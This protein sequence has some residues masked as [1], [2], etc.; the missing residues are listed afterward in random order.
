MC[1]GSPNNFQS[2]SDCDVHADSACGVDWSASGVEY[3]DSGELLLV[4][5][6]LSELTK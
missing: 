2:E 1:S 4:W 6:S 5:L 3:N